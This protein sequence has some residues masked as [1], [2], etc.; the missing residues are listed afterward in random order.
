MVIDYRQINKRLVADK[1]P[2]PRIDEILDQLGR[3]KYFSCLYLIS[4]FHQ[5]NPKSRDITLFSTGRGSFRFTRL[6]FG[7]KIS[8]N[9]FQRMMTI[10]FSGLTTPKAF[11]Y[12]DDLMVTAP[13]EK[14]II[15][16][17]REVFTT[18]RKFNLKLHPDKCSFFGHET[19]FL[20]HKCTDKDILPDDAKHSVISNY[21]RP[22]D[23]DAARRFV[24]FANF[25]RRFIRNFA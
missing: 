13:S 17:L 14:Q 18:C 25:Y 7:L 19:T 2:L 12:M 8:P 22:T 24:A 10:A 1:F 4:G 23:V 9:S 5:I 16:N 21:P 15:K 20:G 3:A 11:V 6:P